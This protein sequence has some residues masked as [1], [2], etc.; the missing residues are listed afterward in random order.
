[1]LRLSGLHLYFAKKKLEVFVI[2]K[3][4]EIRNLSRAPGVIL[5]TS[6]KCIT[7]T[8][9]QKASPQKKLGAIAILHFSQ[10]FQET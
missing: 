8:S 9:K 1:M 10:V 3:P 6:Q 5:D 7:K 4:R 2:I